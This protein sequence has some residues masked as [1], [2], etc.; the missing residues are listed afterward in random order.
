MILTIII[1]P[2]ISVNFTKGVLAV[3]F[4]IKFLTLPSFSNVKF[5]LS[6]M[7]VQV[8]CK[9]NAQFNSPPLHG[10]SKMKLCKSSANA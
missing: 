5:N 8:N 3:T 6:L 2:L 1:F 7:S 4:I 10:Q 9:S